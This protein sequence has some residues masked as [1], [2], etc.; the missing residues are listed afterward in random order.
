MSGVTRRLALGGSAASAGL[1]VVGGR[2]AL[3][4]ADLDAVA[5]RT[6]MIYVRDPKA[7]TVVFLHEDSET[8]ITDRQLAAGIAQTQKKAAKLQRA[9]N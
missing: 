7:G 6:P 4:A 5:E 1:A 3:D 8:V 2:A 9:S